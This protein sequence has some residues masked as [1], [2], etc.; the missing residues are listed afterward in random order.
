MERRLQS[1]RKMNWQYSAYSASFVGTGSDARPQNDLMILSNAS[2]RPVGWLPTKQVE[3][4]RQR[5]KHLPVRAEK[6]VGRSR[7][8]QLPRTNFIP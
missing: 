5:L 4:L 1:W 2:N 8:R 6:F 3:R 7:F